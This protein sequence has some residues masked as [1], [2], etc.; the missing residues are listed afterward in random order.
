MSV[1]PLN[2]GVFDDLHMLNN[3]H[4]TELSFKTAPAFRALWTEAYWARHIQGRGFLIA[5]D[6]RSKITSENYDY[7]AAQFS[8]FVYVDR[9]VI[10][11]RARGMGYG[12]E[13]YEALFRDA[14]RAG[15]GRILCEINTDPPNPGSH[16]FHTALGFM[17]LGAPR[18]L[19]NEKTVQYYLR[20]LE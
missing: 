18:L 1:E 13:L 10:S 19:S 14:R 16:R 5:F 11:A 9:I 4:A 8:S 15:H 20:D 17:P 12:R 2:A 6:H 3:D 7:I